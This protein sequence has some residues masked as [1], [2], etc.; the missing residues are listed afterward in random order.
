MKYSEIARQ[1]CLSRQYLSNIIAG[2]KRPSWIAA[3]KLA[4]ATGTD[5]VLWLEG[6]IE[7]IKTA[8][9]QKPDTTLK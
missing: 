6:T 4:I 5:P 3:K 2:R 1:A 8:I 7:E 9:Y